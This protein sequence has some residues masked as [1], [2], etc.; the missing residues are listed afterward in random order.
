MKVQ[1]V[2]KMGSGKGGTLELADTTFGLAFN[3]ALVHQVVT[4]YRGRPL[5]HQGAED[6]RRSARR[7]QE[8]VGA[9]GHR[10]GARRLEPQPDLGRRRRA[11]SPR[12]RAASRRRSTA[13][14]IAARMR[15][16]LS[17]LRAPGSPDRRRRASALEAPKTKLLAST[18]S[19]RGRLDER[20][21]RR[22]GA[23]TRSCSWPRATCRTSKSSRWRA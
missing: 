11:R 1:L 12:S 18:S 9:E 6:P 16:M 13:R 4:A 15:S 8:A 22:R 19:R 14:C 23:S 2:D 7:R 3:E 21:D 17:E 10:P 20:A 5:R